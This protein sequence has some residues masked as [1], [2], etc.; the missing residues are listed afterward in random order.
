MYVRRAN[1]MSALMWYCAV[2]AWKLADA[3][4]P[5]M[6]RHGNSAPRWSIWRARARAWS[7]MPWRKRSRLR[8][9]RGW[10]WVRNGRT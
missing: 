10:V 4:S 1:A 3:S 2:P 6:V 8:A 5:L 9:I 7:S